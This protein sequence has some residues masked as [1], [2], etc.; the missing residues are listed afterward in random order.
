MKRIVLGSYNPA[1][2]MRLLSSAH[3]RSLLAMMLPIVAPAL[4]TAKS[5]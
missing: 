5:D 3:L 4:R 1:R 2:A